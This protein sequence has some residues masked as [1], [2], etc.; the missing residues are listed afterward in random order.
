V[1][2]VGGDGELAAGFEALNQDRVEHGAR[3]IDR[4]GV[5]RRSRSNDDEL[6]VGGFAHRLIPSVAAPGALP[7]SI[8]RPGSPRRANTHAR[9][10]CGW[11]A[12]R[13]TDDSNPS[14]A[15]RAAKIGILRSH[16]RYA[17]P[18]RAEMRTSV[19][20]PGGTATSIPP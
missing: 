14:A 8:G 19:G 5:T 11:Q 4:G 9:T 1:L 10:N 6:A 2:D 3:R 20:Q 15:F 12:N 13:K 7:C 16:A 17:R 18:P